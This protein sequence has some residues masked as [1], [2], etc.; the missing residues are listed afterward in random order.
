MITLERYLDRIWQTA[1]RERPDGAPAVLMAEYRDAPRYINVMPWRNASEKVLL[2]EAAS[3]ALDQTGA[4]RYAIIFEAWVVAVPHEAGKPVPD[5]I[6]SLH[7][8]RFSVLQITAV[9]RSPRRAL[10]R[11]GRIV[12]E[13]K[14]RR[15]VDVEARSNAFGR[16]AELFPQ[17]ATAN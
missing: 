12:G 8:D 11:S 1:I 9:D 13:G 17:D 7:A 10:L 2:L 5:V 16:L 6:P 15:I 4:Y 14:A 3:A